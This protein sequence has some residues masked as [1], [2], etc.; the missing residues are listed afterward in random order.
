[1]KSVASVAVGDVPLARAETVTGQMSDPTSQNFPQN[2]GGCFA[3]AGGTILALGLL[4]VLYFL[5]GFGSPEI[6]KFRD[7]CRQQELQ[8][9]AHLAVRPDYDQV[10]LK[11]E[12]KLRQFLRRR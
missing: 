12:R 2:Q 3:I 7:Q 1:M 8:E 10:I 6:K 4:Y 9:S 11:C 5:G